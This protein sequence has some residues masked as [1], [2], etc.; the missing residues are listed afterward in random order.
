[1]YREQHG[2][3]EAA[4]RPN[5]KRKQL[6]NTFIS[7]LVEATDRISNHFVKDLMILWDLGALFRYEK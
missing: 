3:C 5:K 6:L 4:E 1:V 2:R 7:V